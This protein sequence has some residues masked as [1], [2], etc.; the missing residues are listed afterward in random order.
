MEAFRKHKI[1]H[2]SASNI[3][4]FITNPAEWVINYI[5]KLPFPSSAAAE[6]GKYIEKALFHILG[7]G[8]SVEKALEEQ[9]Y[10]FAETCKE[11]KVDK[12]EYLKEKEF[13]EKAIKILPKHLSKFGKITGYQNKIGY[14][15]KGIDIIGYTDFDF[16]LPDGSPLIL[17]LKT[18]KK[19]NV[20]T[21][22]KIAQHIYKTA[23]NK[24]NKLFYVKVL[25]TK[26]EVEEYELT[27]E[28][29]VKIPL[30]I[31]Q[32]IENMNY[33][34]SLANSK[35]DFKRLITPNPDDWKWNDETKLKARKDI[36]GF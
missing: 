25:K 12:E 23:T 6:R 36:W 35:D 4:T 7:N 32:A 31:H 3:N 5:Y 19:I 22:H 24:P 2:I 17:D 1:K 30:L 26:E 10:F 28:D 13:V 14:N 27:D 16:E 9:T 18:T 15:Y 21:G 33:L 8:V 11:M 20:S 34:C 29:N